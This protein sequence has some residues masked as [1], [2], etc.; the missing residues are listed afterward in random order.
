MRRGGKRHEAAHTDAE[1]FEDFYRLHYPRVHRFASRRVPA[2]DVDDVL[3]ETF[4]IA[5][6]RSQN[7]PTEIPQ[8]VGWLLVT[9]RHVIGNHHRSTRRLHALTHRLRALAPPAELQAGTTNRTD[10]IT[11]QRIERTFQSL[12]EAD[13]LILTLVAWDE[14]TPDELAAV[15]GCSPGAAKT[16]LSRARTRLRDAVERGHH[17]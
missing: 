2:H 9:A 8:Q 10:F 5:L 7:V 11:D 4:A 17:G 3:V 13:R 15:L 1:A 12:P 6:R 16:R 14:C